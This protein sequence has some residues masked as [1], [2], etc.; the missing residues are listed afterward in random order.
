ML[1]LK[2][3]TIKLVAHDKTW[4]KAYKKMKLEIETVA[5]E[6]ITDIQHV[7]STSIYDILAKPIL[8]IAV[9]VRQEVRLEQVKTAFEKIELEFR[10]DSGEHGGYLFVKYADEDIVSHHIHVV[11]EGDEQ[12]RSWIFFRDYLNAHPKLAAT[13]SSLKL[14]LMEAAQGN[15]AWYTASKHD[16]IQSILQKQK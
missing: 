7:G 16:F 5:A 13:Y 6:L 4:T 15:R 8:D 14:K 3:K 1:G 12:M 2:R 10:R 11:Y 9:S